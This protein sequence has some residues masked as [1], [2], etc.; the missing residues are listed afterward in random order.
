VRARRPPTGL[1]WLADALLHVGAAPDALGA[2][3]HGLGASA[4]GLDHF[5]D[6]ELHRLKALALLMLGK[7]DAEITAAFEQSLSVAR[8][9]E[10]ALFELKTATDFAEFIAKRGDLL[11]AQ[12]MLKTALAKIDGFAPVV[13]RAMRV[14]DAL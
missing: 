4:T 1:A 12:D 8:E 3:E 5:Y 9:S 7:P 6:A 11:R 14:R 2:I 10:H 13:D